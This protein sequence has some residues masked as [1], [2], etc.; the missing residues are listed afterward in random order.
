VSSIEVVVF[1]V[2]GVLVR[3][4]EF[5]VVMEETYGIDRERQREFFHGAFRD[6]VSGKADLKEAIA[7]FLDAWSWPGSVEHCLTTWFEADAEQNH[8]ALDIAA[9]LRSSG[10]R[11]YVA[12]TQERHRSAY[13]QDVVGLGPRFDG[14]F[15]S[16][17]VGVTKADPAF[18]ETV[19]KELGVTADAILFF[20]DTP[21]I[22]DTARRAGWNAEIYEIGDDLK[23]LLRRYGVEV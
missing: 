15:F 11:V 21:A 5:G 18:F 1:D 6:C 10:L 19:T 14:F 20:D 2:D 13:L 3:A 22:V 8:E 23:A 9:D 16:W 4:G 7:P 17:S 12:S